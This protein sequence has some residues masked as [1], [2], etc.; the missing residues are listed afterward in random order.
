MIKERPT[1]ICLKALCNQ[2]FVSCL[3]G[4]MDGISNDQKGV[5]SHAL[6]FGNLDLQRRFSPTSAPK[7]G[8]VFSMFE[9]YLPREKVVLGQYYT[10]LICIQLGAPILPTD[11]MVA[12][13]LC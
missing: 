9:W 10:N 8:I 1:C 4:E 12:M 7:I 11:A 6:M 13:I 5:G 2:V 3:E